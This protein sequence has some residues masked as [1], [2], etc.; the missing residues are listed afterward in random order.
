M[1]LCISQQYRLSTLFQ[2]AS[3]QPSIHKGILLTW[4]Y[5]VC[6]KGR[7]NRFIASFDLHKQ[8]EKTTRS[9]YGGKYLSSFVVRSSKI[10]HKN[11]QESVQQ[12][13]FFLRT[14]K[15]GKVSTPSFYLLKTVLLPKPKQTGLRYP[16][17]F[18]E[19]PEDIRRLRISKKGNSRS[20]R[21]E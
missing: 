20:E 18:V 12:Q 19:N 1:H 11:T 14:K 4:L 3:E 15:V 17:V 13:Q 9:S 21:N 16:E 10:L 5:V 7:G 8:S 2:R 6:C